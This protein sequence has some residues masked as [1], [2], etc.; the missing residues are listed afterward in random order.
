MRFAY[1]MS[2]LQEEPG[3]IAAEAQ[4]R[5]EEG[6]TKDVRAQMQAFLQRRRQTQPLGTYNAG[7]VL[8]NPPGDFAGRLL[9][10]AE[11]KGMTSGDAIVSPMHANF[12]VNRGEA[13]AD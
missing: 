8:N 13:T 10:Q 3:L 2:R 5:L 12:I 9:E 11:C 7:S 1:R 4:M 6:V